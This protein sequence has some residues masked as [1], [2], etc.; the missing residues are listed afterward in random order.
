MQIS[1]KISDQP[2]IRV[3]IRKRPLNRKEVGRNEQDVVEVV[4]NN[5]VSVRY[6][7]YKH[8]YFPAAW[9]QSKRKYWIMAYYLSI[10]FFGY[11]FLISLYPWK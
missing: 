10:P 11:A 4:N 6:Q 9:N 1:D 5:E 2:K 8:F 3:V 7:K